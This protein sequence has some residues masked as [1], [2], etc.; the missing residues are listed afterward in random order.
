M[1]IKHFSTSQHII[2]PLRD[3]PRQAG[4]VNF[5]YQTL[6]TTMTV[7]RRSIHS[8]EIFHPFVHS[9]ITLVPC[10]Q[11]Q[12]CCNSRSTRSCKLALD[13]SPPTLP[14]I[15][16]L[17]PDFVTTDGHLRVIGRELTSVLKL[18][19]GRP[20][21]EMH[22]LCWVVTIVA[23]V[24]PGISPPATRPLRGH[25][26]ARLQ[27]AG[28]DAPSPKPMVRQCFAK[29]CVRSPGPTLPPKSGWPFGSQNCP[30][31]GLA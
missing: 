31:D 16:T 26:D 5:A 8:H 6:R 22:D 29:I 10:G 17:G 25:S 11:T 14:G 27:P 1:R 3:H 7:A 20:T 18:Q 9:E 24:E 12:N 19:A 30:F 15:S 21:R 4:L 23:R 28:N 13:R 2:K